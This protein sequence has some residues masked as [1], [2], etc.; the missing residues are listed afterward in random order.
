MHSAGHCGGCVVNAHGGWLA[1]GAD[2]LYLSATHSTD[3]P[4]MAPGV[5]AFQRRHCICVHD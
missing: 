1:L 4:Q 3:A 2:V 5:G